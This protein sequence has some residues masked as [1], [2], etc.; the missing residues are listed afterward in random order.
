MYASAHM[1]VRF[2]AYLIWL[3]GYEPELELELGLKLGFRL[4]LG[5]A[6]RCEL[7]SSFGQYTKCC[8]LFSVSLLVPVFPSGTAS[9]FVSEVGLFAYSFRVV[10]G[11]TPVANY[12]AVKVAPIRLIINN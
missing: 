10:V 11:R 2:A 12:L 7:S 5:F 3:Y 4:R 1:P 8:R 6:P 9:G